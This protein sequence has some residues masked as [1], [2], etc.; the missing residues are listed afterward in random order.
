MALCS[1][2]FKGED[3]GPQAFYYTRAAMAMVDVSLHYT[4]LMLRAGVP[5]RN[6]NVTVWV[7]SELDTA[8]AGC[9]HW[10]CCQCAAHFPSLCWVL[11]TDGGEDGIVSRLTVLVSALPGRLRNRPRIH[12]LQQAW[13]GCVAGHRAVSHGRI[14]ASGHRPPAQVSRPLQIRPAGNNGE[15]VGAARARLVDVPGRENGSHCAEHVP[16][17]GAAG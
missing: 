8:L 2:C 10:L 16:L 17:R 3:I 4:G 9:S 12:R 5:F 1:H 11:Q 14:A 15:Q 13:R 7:D 6:S